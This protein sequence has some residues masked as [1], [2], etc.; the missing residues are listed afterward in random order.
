MPTNNRALICTP[1]GALVIFLQSAAYI[2]FIMLDKDIILR[3]RSID[4]TL[5]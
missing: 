4:A 5:E 1:E 2:T 3:A